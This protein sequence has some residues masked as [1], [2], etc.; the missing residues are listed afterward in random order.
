M[1][2]KDFLNDICNQIKYKP[3]RNEISEEFKNHIEEQKEN[4]ILEGI[5][6]NE[7][8]EKVVA[9]MGDAIEIGKKLN[10]I[11]KPKMN[12]QLFIL[13][14]I[15][16][17]F[18]FLLNYIKNTD[19]WK[20][21]FITIVLNIIPCIIFYFLDYK[22]LQK[23]SKYFYIVATLII[24]Y[25]EYL[26]ETIIISYT[27]ISL[28][29]YI[30]AFVGLIQNINKND[31]IK[32]VLQNKEINIKMTKIVITSSI[33][34]IILLLSVKSITSAAILTIVYLII[35]TIKLLEFKENRIKNIAILWGSAVL[36]GILTITLLII[37][38]EYRVNRIISSFIPETDPY[39][40]GYQGMIQKEV[41][42]CANLLGKTDNVSLE[43]KEFFNNETSN[44]PFIAILLNYG[45][46]IGILMIIIVLLFNI[47]IIYDAIKIKDKY[48]KLLI[49]GIGVLFILRSIFC[50]LMNLN[51]GIKSNFDIPFI[52]YGIMNLIID[53]ISLSLIFSI[54]RRKD[55]TI[56]VSNEKYCITK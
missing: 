26:Q 5:S 11:H 1:K 31:K 30:I 47:K 40:A 51:L 36:L 54:Y 18:G 10:K 13:T 50:I 44:F 2:A 38:G 48:G 52:S 4:Y 7:A 25:F 37:G 34:S 45:V 20:V 6:E 14:L 8:E 35:S 12:I 15:L 32:L 9:Q 29:L 28:T 46:L 16:F 49:I 39:G 56:L 55:I 22:K 19:E 17:E 27:T 24:I 21:N 23:Y 41:I 3:I 53:M 33:F 42:N 43:I